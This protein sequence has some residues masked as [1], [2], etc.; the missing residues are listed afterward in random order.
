MIEAS[1]QSENDVSKATSEPVKKQKIEDKPFAEFVKDH[2][3]PGLSKELQN[4]G[5]IKSKL[6]LVESER[7]VIGDKC[8]NIV[9]EINEN[10]RFW[11]SFASDSITSQKTISLA[12]SKSEASILESFLIDEK[13]ITLK[14]LIS[15]LIQRL[16]CQKW[17]GKN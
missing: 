11:I 15:R 6:E 8:W 17:L 12:E 7:P 13:K 1:S 3:L 2:L 4:N 5:Q 16:N 10:R 14:L 9:G